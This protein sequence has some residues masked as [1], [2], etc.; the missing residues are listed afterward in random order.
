LRLT[1]TVADDMADEPR[2][3]RRAQV[4]ATLDY[5]KLVA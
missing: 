4:M 3:L 5:L 1:N 2:Y